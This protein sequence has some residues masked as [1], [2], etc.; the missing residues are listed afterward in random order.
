MSSTGLLKRPPALPTLGASDLGRSGAVRERLGRSGA[1]WSGLGAFGAVWGVLGRSGG[2]WS[3]LGRPGAIWSDLERSG[4]S[5]SELQRAAILAC[6]PS[7]RACFPAC[8]PACL[9]AWQ[10]ACLLSRMQPPE[11]NSRYYAGI[12]GTIWGGLGRSDVQFTIVFL[13]SGAVCNAIH[14]CIPAVWGGLQC[15]SR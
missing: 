12:R 8:L 1:I 9:P 4:A 7:T 2:I 15:E 6:L 11:A 10:P 13:R 14:D 5:W 3:D